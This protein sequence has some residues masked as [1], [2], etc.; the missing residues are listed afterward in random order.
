MTEDIASVFVDPRPLPE[1]LL[2]LYNGHTV[3][4]CVHC[5]VQC[6]VQC[7][8]HCT[9]HNTVHECV[10]TAHTIYFQNRALPGQ[11]R[12]QCTNKEKRKEIEIKQNKLSKIHW[13]QIGLCSSNRN[14]LCSISRAKC[15]RAFSRHRAIIKRYAK[16]GAGGAKCGADP[17]LTVYN[18]CIRVDEG[19]QIL[20][21]TL[22]S[23]MI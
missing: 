12:R 9:L 14:V 4:Y 5:T 11:D 6:I 22:E 2:T 23:N 7:T 20:P 21:F 10:R 13:E 19:L 18:G 3:L 8:V 17:A 1:D 15:S 16:S